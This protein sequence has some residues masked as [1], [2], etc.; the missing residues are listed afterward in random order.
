MK[1]KVGKKLLL[2]RDECKPISIFFK[3]NK[4]ANLRFDTNGT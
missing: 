1:I 4:C 2:E 3:E